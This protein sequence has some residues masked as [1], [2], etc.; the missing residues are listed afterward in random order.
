MIDNE[1]YDDQNIVWSKICTKKEPLGKYNAK[2]NFK[3]FLESTGSI[4]DWLVVRFTYSRG[5]EHFFKLLES[6][7]K[8]FWITFWPG[9][10]Y[11]SVFIIN[12]NCIATKHH[13]LT[14]QNKQKILNTRTL[15][16]KLDLVN[17]VVRSL[18]F[19]KLSLFT[20][21]CMDKK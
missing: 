6:L 20:K 11:P 2:I 21:S 13:Q 4:V 12:L 19:T 1:K 7:L 9:K 10:R 18:L 17:M 16:V 5:N 3:L 15:E 8:K 14:L